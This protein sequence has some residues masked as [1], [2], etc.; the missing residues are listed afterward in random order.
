M[1]N[2]TQ[3]VILAAGK[4]TR[5]GG[6]ELP[7]VLRP[8]AGRPM[9]NY[10][11]DSIN[12]SGV[13]QRPVV[14]V[15]PDNYKIIK[16]V[17]NGCDYVIQEE[18]KGTGHAVGCTKNFLW[19]KANHILI[20]Y[21]DQPFVSAETIGKLNRIHLKNNSVLT[22]MTTKLE[23]FSDWR[24]AFLDFG[25]IVRNGKGQIARIVEKKD[26]SEEELQIKEVNPS[27]FCFQADWLWQ[28][29]DSLNCNNKQGEYY[30]TDLMEMAIFQGHE[31]S[32]IF[33]EPWE[34]LGV[35]TLE[36]LKDAE[37]FLLI[38]GGTRSF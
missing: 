32:S 14:I 1:R 16:D 17:L 7:K 12:K 34:C 10:L 26:A 27:Y 9:I 29:I 15:A 24:R 23:D 25:R 8:L 22:A 33:C 5:M 38:S 31:V 19:N 35:N 13:C 20:L 4:G 6:G 36:H 21:G 11:I 2:N 30:L 28:N 18:Q 37:Q 3:I